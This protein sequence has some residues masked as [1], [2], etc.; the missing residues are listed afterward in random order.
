[1]F[2]MP[3]RFPLTVGIAEDD[4]DAAVAKPVDEEVG[5]CAAKLKI[6]NPKSETQKYPFSRVTVGRGALGFRISDFGF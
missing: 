6:R 4:V 2:L 3:R 1:M 5:S